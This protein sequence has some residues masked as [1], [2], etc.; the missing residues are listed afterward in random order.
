MRAARGRPFLVVAGTVVSAAAEFAEAEVAAHEKNRG[1]VEGHQPEHTA[2]PHEIGLADEIGSQNAT[3]RIHEVAE[4]DARVHRRVVAGKAAAKPSGEPGCF[5]EA[6][7][8]VDEDCS[9]QE[10]AEEKVEGH[11]V[12]PVE[13][14]FMY[15]ITL[16]MARVICRLGYEK[17]WSCGGMLSRGAR[18][19]R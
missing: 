18:L 12:S 13:G 2:E 17:L 6:D 9:K 19:W 15:T 3:D 5:P 1:A 8:R 7:R 11:C 16:R 14:D 10:K 4:G